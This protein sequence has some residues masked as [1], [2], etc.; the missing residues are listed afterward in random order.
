MAVVQMRHVMLKTSLERMAFWE[1]LIMLEWTI[2]D[3]SK[4][5]VTAEILE[6]TKI[7]DPILLTYPVPKSVSE[8]F[9][10]GIKNMNKQKKND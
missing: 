10:S 6:R 3:V 8:T 7:T 5:E 2:I 4:L 9:G 1:W